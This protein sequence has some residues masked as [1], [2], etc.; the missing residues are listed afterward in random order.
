MTEVYTE[1]QTINNKTIC[2]KTARELISVFMACFTTSSDG[3]LIADAG[4][5]E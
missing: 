1:I 2:D 3:T 4:E 5:V